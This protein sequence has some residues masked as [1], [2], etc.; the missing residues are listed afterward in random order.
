MRCY[1]G[2]VRRKLTGQLAPRNHDHD[3]ADDC[4]CGHDDHDDHDNN[5]YHNDYDHRCN[6]NA[7]RGKG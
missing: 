4:L 7:A 6:H 1:A 3:A 2:S 5:Y